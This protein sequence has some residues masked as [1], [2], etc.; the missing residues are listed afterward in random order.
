MASMNHMPGNAY[1]SV[2]SRT[3]ANALRLYREQHQLS[4]E[5]VA[6]M[7]GVSASKISRMETG[8]SGLQIDD[9]ASLLGFYKVPA[10][11]R[12]E[13]LDL[14]RKGEEMGWWERQAGLPK[15]WRA[16][17]DFENKALRIHNYELL[18]VPGLLQTAEYTRALVKAIDPTVSD[19][20]L[21]T[22]VSARMARQTLLSRSNAPQYLAVIHEAALRIQVGDQAVMRRQLRQL[23]DAAER[24]NVT[25]VVVPMDAG[26]HVGL[27]GSF[28]ILEFRHEP[29]IVHVENQ[30]TGL[31]LEDPADL[32]GYRLALR[33]IL[34]VGLAPGA[35]ADLLAALI[36]E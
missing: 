22:L 2:R 8:K 21:D 32:E 26:P 18:M 34:G 14:M 29:A 27:R 4:C 7:L 12:K 15:L 6:S 20:E 13:L 31:F 10:P 30:V 36:K 3:V 28:M 17:I 19:Y 1:T 9:V 33:N 5:D 24:P 16:L 25:V 23:Q 11:R 35:T